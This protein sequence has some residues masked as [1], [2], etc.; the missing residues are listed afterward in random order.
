[1]LAIYRQGA[2]P[3]PNHFHVLLRPHHRVQQQPFPS[4]CAALLFSYTPTAVA[5]RRRTREAKQRQNGKEKRRRRHVRREDYHF[6]RKTHKLRERVEKTNARVSDHY[7]SALEMRQPKSVSE[8][9]SRRDGFEKFFLSVPGPTGVLV[10][11]NLREQRTCSGG[12]GTLQQ[13][14]TLRIQWSMVGT[15][16]VACST[17]VSLEVACYSCGQ[18]PT[19]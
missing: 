13:R 9:R 15:V 10:C 12:S 3:I 6:N 1:M 5:R 7:E 18:Q 2:S 4:R 16:T 14:R 8:H 11:L 17:T 19:T